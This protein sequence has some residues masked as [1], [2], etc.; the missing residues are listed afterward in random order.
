MM[1]IED[2][3]NPSASEALAAAMAQVGNLP[4]GMHYDTSP[5]YAASG[6]ASDKPGIPGLAEA[7]RQFLE[8]Y[9]TPPLSGDFDNLDNDPSDAVS[10]TP[11]LVSDRDH[12]EREALETLRL[13]K[14]TDL[15]AALDQADEDSRPKLE[16]LLKKLEAVKGKD[17]DSIRSAITSASLALS[18]EAAGGNKAA[19][20]GMEEEKTRLWG[21]IGKLNEEIKRDLKKLDHLKT[22]EE[23]ERE[24]DLMEKLDKAQ[25][26]LAQLENDP[27]A[28]PEQKRRAQLAWL[29]ALEARNK[30]ARMTALRIFNDPRSTSEEREAAEGILRNTG[31]Q[32]QRINR[33]IELQQGHRNSHFLKNSTEEAIGKTSK[34]ETATTSAESAFAEMAKLEKHDIAT[35]GQQVSRADLGALT[36]STPQLPQS[37]KELG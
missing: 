33:F 7:A 10:F 1:S 36:Q 13:E 19:G 15:E 28:T 27:N 34:S 17:A 16:A 6:L 2:T 21:E 24:K 5:D 37:G 11:I 18:T 26:D 22:K 3:G 4:A 12:D 23:K 20:G 31:N 32:G 9:P 29:E 35:G 25:A 30:E 14:I 8:N